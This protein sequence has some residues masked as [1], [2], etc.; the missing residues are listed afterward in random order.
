WLRLAHRL[1]PP[2]RRS[3]HG[4]FRVR[5]RELRPRA[6][7]QVRPDLGRRGREAVGVLRRDEARRVA[8]AGERELRRRTVRPRR[9]REHDN[10]MSAPAEAG[11]YYDPYDLA[12]N[13]NPYPVFR[14][15]REEAPLYY[16]EPYDFY[17]ISRADDVERAL[18]D[19]KRLSNAQS[20]ILDF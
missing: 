5:V 15:M 12:I 10:T 17:A 20:D 2:A 16:N 3:E 8:A 14:R 19:T 6:R 4:A 18:A 1:D 11:V 13:T 9:R 7:R